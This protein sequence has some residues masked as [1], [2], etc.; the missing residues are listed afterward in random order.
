MYKIIIAILLLVF[1]FSGPV[2]AEGLKVGVVDGEQLFDQYPGAQEATKK[3]SDAQ[4]ELKD[5]ITESE[6]IYTEFE[7]QKKSEAEKLTK[8]K[9]LQSK[10]DTKAQ[11]TKKMIEMLSGKIE[12]DIMQA[13]KKVST[14]KGIEVVFDKRAVLVGGSDIT[15]EVSEYLK[16]KPIAEEPA[17]SVKPIEAVKK[18]SGKKT[19]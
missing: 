9:E 4:D 2:L 7:K 3:I 8:K 13:I 17:K 11:D 19:N 5:A 6:K 10:I 16:K 14:D 1:A 15:D 18:D 12:D